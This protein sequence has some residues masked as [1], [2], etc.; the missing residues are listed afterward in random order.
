M[1][2]GGMRMAGNT[3]AEIYLAMLPT[4]P[5]YIQLDSP[6]LIRNILGV[7]FKQVVNLGGRLSG[8]A[9]GAPP[10]NR[11]PSCKLGVVRTCIETTWV[12]HWLEMGRS[13]R[14]ISE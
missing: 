10:H 1:C 5:I 13:V 12:A 11:P 8:H 14:V 9:A 2:I 6:S 4:D 3:Q 7:N